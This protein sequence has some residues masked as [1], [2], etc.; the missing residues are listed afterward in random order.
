MRVIAKPHRASI[1]SPA[2]ENAGCGAIS[3]AHVPVARGGRLGSTDLARATLRVLS[4]GL[5]AILS[6]MGGTALAAAFTPSSVTALL[7]IAAQNAAAR[8]ETYSTYALPIGPWEDGTM[9]TRRTEGRVTTSAWHLPQ[10]EAGTLAMLTPLR[11]G[12]QSK[13]WRVIYECETLECGGFDF[14]YS[15]QVLPEPEMHID[16]GDFR[17]ISARR[18]HPEGEEIV[19]LM[20]SRSAGTGLGYVQIIEVA[21]TEAP[22]DT[23]PPSAATTPATAQLAAQLEA[24]SYVLEGLIFA[25]GAAKL[26]SEDPAPLQALAAYLAAHPAHQIALV[27]HTDASGSVAA[28]EALSKRRAEA[29]RARLISHYKVAASQVTAMGAGVMAPRASNQ[30]EEGRAKNRRVEVILTSTR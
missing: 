21:P 10:G 1:A 20:V 4:F 2:R 27:G 22:R 12:L 26:E 7:P 8:V 28:N 30:T 14:R 15:T 19:S 23:A 6:P 11:D 3:R 5:A 13:G 17:F 18:P 24:G 16:L 29:V 9:L 25:S